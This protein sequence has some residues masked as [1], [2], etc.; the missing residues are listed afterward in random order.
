MECTQFIC[1]RRHCCDFEPRQVA[2]SSSMSD[3]LRLEG[4]H[5]VKRYLNIIYFL[6]IEY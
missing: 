2:I 5:V 1:N 3:L 4:E 6:N